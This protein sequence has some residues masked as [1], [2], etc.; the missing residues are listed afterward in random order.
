MLNYEVKN[1][2]IHPFKTIKKQQYINTIAI[3]KI[4]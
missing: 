1:I 4:I 3:N 2:I